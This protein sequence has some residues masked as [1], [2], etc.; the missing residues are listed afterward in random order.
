MVSFR[1]PLFFNPYGVGR[2]VVGMTK[3]VSVGAG[4]GV[5]STVGSGVAVG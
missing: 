3:R 5:P 2:V 4:V 1:T